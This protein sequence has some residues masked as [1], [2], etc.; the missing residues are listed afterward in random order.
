ADPVRMNHTLDNVR[1]KFTAA[2]GGA[3][4]IFDYDV[5]DIDANEWLNYTRTFPAGSYEVYLREAVANM[6]NGE[7]VLELVT[8]SANQ[9]DQTTRVLGSFLGLRSGF[10]YRNFP[11]TDGSGLNKA[12]VQL[13]GPATLRLRQVTATP[14][15]AS[16]YEN[17]LIFIPVAQSGPQRATVATLNPAGGSILESATP[18]ISAT[19]L[20]R[21]TTVKT[22]SIKLYINGQAV[23]PVL[24]PSADGVSLTYSLNPLPA[25]GS[26]VSGRVEF[27]DSQNITQTNE[28]TFTLSYNG[29]NAANLVSG[30]GGERG[31]KLRFVQAALEASPLE[32]SLTRAE[33]QLAANSAIPKFAD[34]NFVVQVVN[35]NEAESDAGSIPGDQIVP[36]LEPDI[37]GTDDF[38]VEIQA[39]LDLS[40]GVHHF[41]VMS[42]DGFKVSSGTSL[43]DKTT[44]PLSFRSG[45]TANQT[46]D[47]YVPTAG[48]YPFRMVWYERG[49]GANAE[50]FSVDP[51]T[52]GRTLINDPASPNAVK[53]Y[54]AVTAPAVIIESAAEAAGP[55]SADTSATINT[56]TRTVVIASTGAN[57]RFYRINAPAKLKISS[58]TRAGT[59]LTLA[60]E[61]S[62]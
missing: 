18:A 60:Y 49:G 34:T 6:A 7:S 36:G 11:L 62:N 47:F 54:T 27:T 5:Q 46:F 13:S 57:R 61:T 8:G 9:P 43:T 17:Y 20:N 40:A 23:S 10:Q 41:G 24:T 3:V 58:A 4:D 52:G 1:S 53:A 50:W 29:L 2:G 35:F 33:D 26:L 19:I 28:W 44:I 32:N 59:T 38:A 21:D 37:N 22:E 16:R 56:T 31:F 30:P 39:Y 14:S 55:Y 15:D 45:G 42:D 25:T 51:Q 12:V 48:L